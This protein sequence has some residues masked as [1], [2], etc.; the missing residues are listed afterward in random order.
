MGTI[1]PKPETESMTPVRVSENRERATKAPL[2][3]FEL[4][5]IF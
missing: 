2:D 1:V 5:S 4:K 3:S